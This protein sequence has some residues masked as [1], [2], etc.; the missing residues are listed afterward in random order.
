MQHAYVAQML[1]RFD[2]ARGAYEP[3]DELRSLYP[4]KVQGCWMVDAVTPDGPD[5]KEGGAGASSE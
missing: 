2:G 4:Q 1:D 3:N 5:G